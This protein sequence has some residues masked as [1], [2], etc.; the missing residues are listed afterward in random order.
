[1][2]NPLFLLTDKVAIVTGGGVGIGAA[3]AREFAKAGAQVVVTSRKLPNLEKV[4]EEIKAPGRRSLAIAAD[5]RKPEDVDNLVQRTVEEFGRIDILV[6]NAGVS[7]LCPLEEMTPGGW[8]LI[9]ATDL[10]GAFLCSRAAG[11]LMIK[12]NKG[13]IINISSRA[14]IYG[15]PHMAHYGAAKAGLQN[16]T[17]S[18]A[19]EWARYNINVNCVAPGPTST[20]AWI[21]NIKAGGYTEVP[22]AWNA[23]MRW[24]QPEEIA[25]A[26]VFLASEAAN[27]IT[28]QTLAV[29]G[30]P[31]VPTRMGR[32]AST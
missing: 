5:V 15:S 13:K 16:F 30:G 25:Y 26:V 21:A 8:D 4:A 7:F 9:I 3:I 32:A 2:I 14:G 28:G 24:A 22:P 23:Q 11:R 27:F 1:M 19:M 6:N 10:R 31:Y 29:D 20:E 17:M 18:L 12:Q